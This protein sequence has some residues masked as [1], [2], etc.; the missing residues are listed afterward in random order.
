[1]SFVLRSSTNS[2]HEWRKASVMEERRHRLQSEESAAPTGSEAAGVQV[3]FKKAPII[4]WRTVAVFAPSKP[5]SE[6]EPIRSRRMMDSWILSWRWACSPAFTR[7]AA[8]LHIKEPR[9]ISEFTIKIYRRLRR[10]HPH[11]S[12]KL[13]ISGEKGQKIINSGVDWCSKAS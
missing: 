3:Q 10:T 11:K 2:S 5:I 13:S 6:L 9:L 1:M 12:I 7:P 4:K 8:G